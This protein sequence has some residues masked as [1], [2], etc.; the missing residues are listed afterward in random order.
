MT[1]PTWRGVLAESSRRLGDHDARRIVEEASGWQ[2]AELYLHLDEGVGKRAL[3]H[4]DEMLGRRSAGEPLQY[5]LGRWGFRTLD[6]A[7]DGRALI[8]RP[9]TE[10]VVEVALAEL[11]RQGGST[12]PTT[13]LDLGTGS[14][15]IALAVCV[16]RLRT[17]VWAVERS[18]EAARLARANAA[19]IGRAAARLSIVEGHWF[20]PLPRALVGRF[21]LIVS[22]PPYVPD[23]LPLPAE[24]ME[25]EPTE[26]L[27]GGVDGLDDVRHILAEVGTWL[28][29]GGAV[30]I[31]IDP[32]QADPAAR[33]AVECG[34]VDVA[35]AADLTGRPR[36]LSGR[37]SSEPRDA[38]AGA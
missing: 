13:V 16:E 4:H 10:Q 25:W 23:D 24:V 31:E 28:R 6:L 11:D 8:P 9:E 26:A 34:L 14:G 37:R 27:R 3:A 36:I 18:S 29:P 38:G 5:V 33:R 20:D 30:V 12:H 32:A 35:V 21:H 22:N 2:G 19:G 17:E 7:V 1:D 15:A